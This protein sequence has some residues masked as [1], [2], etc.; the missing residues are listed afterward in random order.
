MLRQDW[1]KHPCPIARSLDVVGDPWVM[2]VLREALLGT[3]KFEQFREVLQVADNVLARRLAQM[4]EAGL[5]LRRPY[6]GKQRM[7]HEYVIT[8]AAAD[9]L[10]VLDA[11]AKWSEKH[12][13]APARHLEM[14]ILHRSGD[15]PSSSPTVCST[16]G[17]PLTSADRV[18]QR[19][20]A[21][22]SAR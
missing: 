22:T 17:E 16:C 21:G 1:S 5:L 6:R 8:D 14:S 2:L 3:T 11:L 10:P 9:F 13:Q 19:R 15:H 4:V 12:T 20:W 18:Y 7:Q